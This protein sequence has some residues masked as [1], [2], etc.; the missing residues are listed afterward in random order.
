[1][2]IRRRSGKAGGVADAG[3]VEAAER[4]RRN[5]DAFREFRTDMPD[6]G[7]LEVDALEV[8]GATGAG[9]PEQNDALRAH[10]R[11]R[12][13]LPIPAG[14]AAGI[15]A[16]GLAAGVEEV[17]AGGLRKVEAAEVHSQRFSSLGLDGRRPDESPVRC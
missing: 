10:D 2:G 7:D 9:M 17:K 8:R 11:V 4:L 14:P 15:G 12:P 13:E 3:C 16:E 5:A 6:I 1:G